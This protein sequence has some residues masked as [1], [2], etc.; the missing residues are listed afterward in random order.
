MDEGGVFVFINAGTAKRPRYRDPEAV[1]AGGENFT[2]RSSARP[3]F[4]DLDG[5]GLGELLCGGYVGG[6]QILQNI[7][8]AAKPAWSAPSPLPLDG[9]L[10][11]SANGA[12]PLAVD[13]NKDGLCDLLLGRR[14]GRVQYFEGEKV[15]DV[16][17]LRDRG[18][19]MADGAILDVGLGA[20][21]AAGDVTGDGIID[22]VVGNQAG[23]VRIVP[24]LD[25]SRPVLRCT[26]AV[27]RDPDGNG[28]GLLDPGETAELVVC[29][30]N[31]GARATSVSGRLTCLTPGIRVQA[32]PASFGTIDAHA[33][34]SNSSTP[35]RLTATTGRDHSG[36]C[37]FRLD[38]RDRRGRETRELTFLVGAYACDETV[39]S[40]WE[41]MSSAAKLPYREGVYEPCRIK[42]GF[43]FP[44]YGRV[45]D[46]LHV[47]ISGR[48][49]VLPP[50][51]WAGY[52]DAPPDIAYPNGFLAPLWAPL[53]VSKGTVSWTTAGRE[54]ER[55]CVIEWLEMPTS[56]SAI[57]ETVTFQVS[58]HENG[59]ITY[60]YKSFPPQIG[61]IIGLESPDGRQA[62]CCPEAVLARLS[63]GGAVIFRPVP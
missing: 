45:Y 32:T 22:L 28:N 3:D 29:L 14:D 63:R 58:L 44:F 48:V 18:Y 31:A 37:A 11:L 4:A 36:L 19:I 20:T 59:S 51:N 53:N 34:A 54:P 2:V 55:R 6:I 57:G 41:D 43:D 52:R 39:D 24:G 40:V 56:F 7:G 27:M 62:V 49:Y 15:A 23:Y 1:Q 21:P 30:T 50:V 33:E 47:G 60:R 16:H 13:W 35:F 8:T 38:W 12:A 26:R 42:P 61:R 25:A 17:R 10:P 5:D 46:S 9:L